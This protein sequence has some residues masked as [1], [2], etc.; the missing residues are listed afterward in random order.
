MG[1]DVERGRESH[2]LSDVVDD[3][4]QSGRIRLPSTN[5]IEGPGRIHNTHSSVCSSIRGFS[6]VPR[7]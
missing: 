6:E 5:Y 3:V 7:S 4:P 2:G 1:F